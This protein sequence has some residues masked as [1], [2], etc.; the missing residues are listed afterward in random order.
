[1]ERLKKLLP[2][3]E[4]THISN[5]EKIMST[6][7]NANIQKHNENFEKAY[8]K[9]NYIFKDLETFKTK[10]EGIETFIIFN[11]NYCKSNL[12]GDKIDVCY[13]YH[14]Y[15]PQHFPAVNEYIKKQTDKYDWDSICKK[16][17]LK[18]YKI[19]NG[20]SV[21]I[22]NSLRIPHKITDIKQNL[23]SKYGVN[24]SGER[25]KWILNKD[26]SS[27]I[28]FGSETDITE[29]I[30]NYVRIEDRVEEWKDLKDLVEHQK[31]AEA[32]KYL[33]DIYK[34][35]IYVKKDTDYVEIDSESAEIDETSIRSEEINNNG[36]GSSG[37]KHKHRRKKTKKTKKTKKRKSRKNNRR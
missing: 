15:T 4:E 21:P 32:N 14:E 28:D 31:K 18:K 1:M 2:T 9:T 36:S 35:S 27:R 30:K 37:G 25:G 5:I 22:F 19:E 29:T 7:I 24:I 33:K 3:S 16:V 23:S 6:E 20:V 34:R 11:K 10:N 17:E 26:G 8:K 13:P 12:S